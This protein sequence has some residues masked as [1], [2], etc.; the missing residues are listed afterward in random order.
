MEK[1]QENQKFKLGLLGRNISYSFSR[2]YF[3]KKFEKECINHITYEN[4]DIESIESFPKLIKNT[5]NLKGLNVTI[6]YK[7]DVIAYLD[8]LN[9]KAAAIGAVNTIKVCKNGKLVGYNTDFHGFQ[10]S[11]KPLLEPDHTS[12]L[13][14]GTGGASKAVIYALKNLGIKCSYVSRKSSEKVKYTYDEL[15][16]NIIK[17]HLVIVNCT[18]LG[19]FPN[20]TDCPNIP[21]EAIGKN[22]LLY[23]LIYNP[24]ETQFLKNGK[25]NGATICNGLK[26]LELQAQKAWSIWNLT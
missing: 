12:A 1:G 13:I 3:S 16:E 9:E 23:D 14:L 6:P 4:F 5:L 25:A 21:Y 17:K 8:E 18:P 26:M 22:H 2:T 15:T 7:E 10:E 19:T 11:I 20:I 24:S